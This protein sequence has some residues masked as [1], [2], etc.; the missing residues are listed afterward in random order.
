MNPN[1]NINK[2]KTINFLFNI[3]FNISYAKMQIVKVG[4]EFKLLNYE[5]K[6]NTNEE[7]QYLHCR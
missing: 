3:C 5:F 4:I 2:H 1:K 6:L 7:T